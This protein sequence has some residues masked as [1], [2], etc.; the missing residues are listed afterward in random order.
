MADWKPTIAIIGSGALGSYYGGRLAEHGHDVHFLLRSDYEAVVRKGLTVRSC[1]GDFV[2]PPGTLHVYNTSQRMPRVDLVIVAIKATAND[3]YEAL[4]RPL[5]K[6]NTQILTLQNGLGNEDRLAE[7]FGAER[8]LGGLAFVCVNRIAP[9]IIHHLDYGLIRVGEFV[10]GKTASAERIVSLFTQSGIECNL[11][12]SLRYGR[13]EK[14][15]WN[16]PFNGLGAVLDMATDQLLGH[17]SGEK[18]VRRIMAEVLAAAAALGIQLPAGAIE[19]RIGLTRTMGSY[20]SSMQIDRTL[21]RPMEVE[22]ILGEPVR[23]AERAGIK[24]PHMA[25]LYHLAALVNSGNLQTK[26]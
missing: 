12:K 14:L 19:Q 26:K 21:G 8:I 17:P 18:L 5:V 15:V 6:D 2:L 9:G 4:I 16:V 22:A 25:T 10:E 1:H 7:L 20:R 13:W 11:L 23:A 24:V 3:Q